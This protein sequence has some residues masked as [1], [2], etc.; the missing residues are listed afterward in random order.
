MRQIAFILMIFAVFT[1]FLPAAAKAEGGAIGVLLEVEGT[2]TIT[3]TN[4]SV[5]QAAV[6]D[7]V[8][9]DDVI[10]TGADGRAFLFLMDGTEWTLSENAVFQVNHYAFHPE[11]PDKNKARYSVVSGA[12]RYV[13]GMIAKNQEPDIAI[14]TSVGSIGIRGTDITAAA[15]GDGGYDIYVD[16]G[17][18]EVAN[19]AGK[20]FLTPGQ[21]TF[22]K[23]KRIAPWHPQKWQPERLQRMRQAV[24][25][26][27][28]EAIRARAQNL[29]EKRKEKLKD[30]LQK[31]QE[32]TPQQREQFKEKLQE[33]MQQRRDMTPGEKKGQLQERLQQRR[34]NT[35]QHIRRE[36][37]QDKIRNRRTGGG[38]GKAIRKWR[39]N[40]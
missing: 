37:L 21:G 24:H 9:L 5:K 7:E 23:N 19:D 29:R 2:A 6:D 26:K 18:I 28:G 15:D 38:D 34:E 27:R 22:I 30:Y 32:M 35:G 12:F 17:K 36:E 13:S 1:L 14:D 4:G 3:R 31:R 40:P 39:G 16:E 11:D 20:M 33:K 10:K 8:F 25:L